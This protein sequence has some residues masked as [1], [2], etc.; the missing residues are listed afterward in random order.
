MRKYRRHFISAVVLAVA[1]MVL[2]A[3]ASGQQISFRPFI[4]NGVFFPNP[5]G[6]SQTYSTTG[7]GMDLTGPFFQSLG[8]N[9]RNCGTCHQPNDG[10]SI[11]S[12]DVQQRFV[13]TQG[14]EP[15]FRT[16]DGANCN[17]SIDVSTLEGRSAAYSLLRTR[18]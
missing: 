15:I 18:A 4:P 14:Q 3:A 2:I 7:R 5:G 13:Q 8:T 9:G 16:V 12:A 6:A 11:S 10:M 1:A 17:H